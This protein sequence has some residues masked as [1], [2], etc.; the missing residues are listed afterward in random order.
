MSRRFPLIV[1]LSLAIGLV[2]TLVS[3]FYV[4]NLSIP[5]QMRIVQ[6]FPWIWYRKSATV[7]PDAP[8]YYFLLWDYFV[9]DVAFWSVIAAIVAILAVK[10]LKTRK[11]A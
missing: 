10:W 7:Y 1:P 3:W 8:T 6:G 2:I 5:G 4:Q 9:F 11:Q